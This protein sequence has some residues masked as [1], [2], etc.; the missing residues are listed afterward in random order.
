MDD[1]EKPRL[2]REALDHLLTRVQDGVVSR[3][4]IL[5]LGGNDHDI[6]R[7]LRRRELAVVHPGVYV[8]HT[9][10]PSRAQLEWAAVLFY[11]PAALCRESALP[12]PARTGP[13]HVAVDKT[14][15]RRGI[16]GVTLHRTTGLHGRVRWIM[17][18]PRT[19]YEDAA[20]DSAAASG[21]LF[22]AFTVLANACQT[23]M[24]SAATIAS[25]LRARSRLI[26]TVGKA[27][28]LELLDDLDQGACSVLEREWLILE[29]RHGLPTADTRQRPAT[30]LGRSAYR[31]V[32]HSG[33]G[34]LA[35]LDGRAFHDDAASRDSDADRDLD[36]QVT[37]DLTTVRL[38]Y[39]QVLRNGCRTV[40]S[41]AR[42]LERGGWP[43]P[44]VPCPDCPSEA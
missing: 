16:G 21:D 19:S 31:D 14:R 29:R 37:S 32:D 44:F 11:W 28:L 22:A 4:Q 40:R 20:I 13:I 18:P 36:A 15:H 41:V 10:R 39:G 7:M 2:D 33:F 38:T 9:G 6:A 26:G 17:S 30:V 35:E 1:E 42:L 34:V 23:R 25:T 27:Q 8:N 24:T 12:K 5:E 3:R 43:G